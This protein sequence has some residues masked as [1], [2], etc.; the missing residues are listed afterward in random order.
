MIFT[1]TYFV[2]GLSDTVS[3]NTYFQPAKSNYACPKVGDFEH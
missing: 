1:N 3:E 2:E